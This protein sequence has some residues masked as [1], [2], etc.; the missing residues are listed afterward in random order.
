MAR[1]LRS[2][3]A[4]A[5]ELV[6]YCISRIHDLDPQIQAW[7]EVFEQRAKE[8]A[9]EADRTPADARGPL[10]G[11]PF[12]VKDII[13]VAGF[14]TGCGSN[15]TS[16][17]SAVATGDV[18][19][20]L[21]QCG[22][23]ALGKT[24]TT[25]FAY[26]QPGPTRNPLNYKHT[27][28]GSSSGS[29]AAVAAGMV[30]LAIGTQTAASLIRP[31]AYCG[32][33]GYVAPVGT[34]STKGIV[35]LSSSLDSVGFFSADIEGIEIIEKIETGDTPRKE[36][37]RVL[38]WIPDHTFSCESTMI[39]RLL[40][41]SE[42]L[43]GQ[44]YFVD[45]VELDEEANALIEN[46]STIMA[47]EACRE[48]RELLKQLD[49]VSEPLAELL[50]TGTAI[51]TS[52][53]LAA[54]KETYN[55]RKRLTDRFRDTIFL[56]P[57]ALGPAPIGLETTGSPIMS[58]PWQVLGWPTLNIPETVVKTSSHLPRG[59][60]LI[61]PPNLKKSLVQAAILLNQDAK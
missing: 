21:E 61:G 49:S 35:G 19:T 36:K 16:G 54:K 10:H 58:R 1:A 37:P 13:D 24:V 25:E 60:Q 40:E 22:A 43:T 7:V 30:P 42:E 6:E 20:A 48:R 14:R 28:G 46:H 2:G 55:W 27:P 18:V 41:I 15:L 26:F 29:A 11:I 23:I 51:S 33:Y 17:H 56:A 31:A 52:R 50:E 39:E 5:V 9:K 12:G 53:Y 38:T 44:G 3:D 47:Y 4:S 59:I 34:W 45:Q 32:V 57:S 8:K